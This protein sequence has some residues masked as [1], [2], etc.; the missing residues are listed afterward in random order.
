[1]SA[2]A[3]GSTPSPTLLTIFHEKRL[4]LGAWGTRREV[5]PNGAAAERTSP[6]WLNIT[7]SALFLL[8]TRM[9]LHFI[10]LFS[11]LPALS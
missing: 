11:L 4:S 2:V 10:V 5:A 3:R 8:I 7:E 1:M 9:Y 6:D